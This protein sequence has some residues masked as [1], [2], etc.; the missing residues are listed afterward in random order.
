MS[1]FKSPYLTQ[2]YR[3]KYVER[4]FGHVKSMTSLDVSKMK[5]YCSRKNRCQS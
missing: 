2:N 3:S 5:V 4:S 1:L